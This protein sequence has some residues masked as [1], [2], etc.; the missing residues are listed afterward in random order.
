MPITVNRS[1]TQEVA[2]PIRRRNRASLSRSFAK[3]HH[4]TLHWICLLGSHY[5]ADQRPQTSKDSHSLW[6]MLL[7]WH[8]LMSTEHSPR[9]Y[10]KTCSV[11]VNSLLDQNYVEHTHMKT[12][13]F[14]TNECRRWVP[15]SAMRSWWL[16]ESR[17]ARVWNEYGSRDSEESLTPK[18]DALMQTMTNL[19]GPLAFHFDL[20]PN[21]LD[22]N[23]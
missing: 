2:F 5:C 4:S 20:Y 19:V 3:K 17:R 21:W 16:K 11:F 12:H 14:K 9:W 23:R 7:T 10:C 8:F 15:M 1:R 6:D 22:T 13:N 18:M